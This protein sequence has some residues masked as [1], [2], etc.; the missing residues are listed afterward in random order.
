M[1]LFIHALAQTNLE[2]NLAVIKWRPA[3]PMKALCVLMKMDI[4]ITSDLHTAPIFWL[5]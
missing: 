4:V 2:I 5:G 3:I 1:E